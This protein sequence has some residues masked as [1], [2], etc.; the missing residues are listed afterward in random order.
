MQP[1]LTEVHLFGVSRPIG[2]YGLCVAL[3]ILIAG[4][5][6]ARAAHRAKEDVGG[7]IASIGYTAGAGFIGAWLFFLFVEWARGASV[8]EALSRGGG[9]VFYGAVPTGVL[10][11]YFSCRMM[12]VD[13]WKMVDLS[14]P[15]IA[16]GHALGR[17]GCLL[18]GCC[19]GAEWHGP[20]AIT[21][22]H[23]M[24]P[25]S[26]PSVPRH[27]TQI[28]EALGL[29]IIALVFALTPLDSKWLG[30]PGSGQR[31]AS[32]LVVYGILRSIVEACRGDGIRG[33]YFG[34]ITTSQLVSLFGIALGLYGIVR[35]QRASQ[36][37][38]VA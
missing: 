7:I 5:L 1:I 2:G 15:A 28:Y 31:A 25:A 9:L 20:W 26:H 29:S 3:G 21:F 12:K 38:R 27:P 35:A 32:Y 34:F 24:S 19:F 13:W 4:L 23:P 37:V 8:S 18:G 6:T 22:T 36:Q 33:V 11:S 16:I 10:A 17:I 14:I 30:K